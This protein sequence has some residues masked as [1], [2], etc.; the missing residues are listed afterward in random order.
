M[1]YLSRFQAPASGDAEA[2]ENLETHT[3]G[4]ITSQPPADMGSSV[5]T[6]VSQ[7]L[8]SGEHG[9]SVPLHPESFQIRVVTA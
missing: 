1:I 5:D 4:L 8:S 2:L 3:G 7:A 9:A 6:V